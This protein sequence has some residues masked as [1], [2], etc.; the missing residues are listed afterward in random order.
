M[1][2]R[3]NEGKGLKGA[4]VLACEW[5][6]LGGLMYMCLC[7]ELGKGTGWFIVVGRKSPTITDRQSQGDTFLPLT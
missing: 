6:L 4:C 3:G 1:A 7:V 5:T 2:L